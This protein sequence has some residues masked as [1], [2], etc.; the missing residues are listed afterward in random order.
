MVLDIL[1]ALADETRLRLMSILDAGEYTVQE[2]TT[3]LSMGQSR[4]S[5]HLKILRD[6]G[7]LDVQHQ[8]TWN[9]YRLSAGSDFPSGLWLSIKERLSDLPVIQRDRSGVA[10]VNE[11]RR[12]RS[13][14]FF[15]QVIDRGDD[16]SEKMLP[17]VEYRQ[18]LL[19]KIPAVEV[20]VEVGIGT[21]ELLVELADSCR[22]LIGVDQS[23]SILRAAAERLDREGVQHKELRLGD[24]SHLPLPDAWADL[25]VLNMVLHH[26]PN[27]AAVLQEVA[28]VLCSQGQLVLADYSTH[29]H[30][31]VREGL[32]DQ[33]LGFTSSDLEALMREAGFEAIE[34]DEFPAVE[35]GAGVLLFSARKTKT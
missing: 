8:G 19:E 13:R 6:A 23:P 35:N 25:L 33:W 10:R 12:T 9:Y 4:I 34:K 17:T 27:P 20:L 2:L 5:R 16:V 1:K 7:L 22:S 14:L 3:I 18:R 11:F 15:D 26:A 32:A 21:G 28:R 29:G 30:D 24:M 31:W